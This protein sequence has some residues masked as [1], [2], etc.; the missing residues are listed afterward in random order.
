M[1]KKTYPT[2]K[3]IISNFFELSG[4]LEKLLNE[5]TTAVK[6]IHPF[7]SVLYEIRVL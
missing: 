6:K 3:E 7:V 1:A 2:T 5:N 4:D